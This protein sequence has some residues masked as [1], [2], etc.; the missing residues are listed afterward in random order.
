MASTAAK[1]MSSATIL[2]PLRVLLA[3]VAYGNRQHRHVNNKTN[4][5]R[6][7]DCP[8]GENRPCRGNIVFREKLLELLL[9]LLAAELL[10]LA[11]H[12]RQPIENVRTEIAV[13]S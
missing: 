13:K 8:H 11:R 5:Q 2:H 1:S 6:M 4:P 10:R 3:A 9:H 7:A 12:Q